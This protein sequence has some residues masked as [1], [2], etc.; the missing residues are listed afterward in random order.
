MAQTAAGWALLSA[1]LLGVLIALYLRISGTQ[2]FG[3]WTSGGKVTVV[4]ILACFSFLASGGAMILHRSAGWA[5][6]A[7]LAWFVMYR[8]QSNANRRKEQAEDE[9]R[10]TNAANHPGIFDK[11]PPADLSLIPG[12]RVNLYDAGTC[13]FMGAVKKPDISV[14]IETVAFRTDQDPNDIFFFHES[15]E[16]IPPLTLSEECA[17]LIR[18]ALVLRDYV[19]LR[20]MPRPEEQAS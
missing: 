19:V 12:E 4:G 18:N 6:P 1:A 20:W 10:R 8:S 5:I 17:A 13:M 7:L 14:L 16:Q 3:N 15:F 2:E 11:P 9:L